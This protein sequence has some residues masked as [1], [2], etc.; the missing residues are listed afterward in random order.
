MGNPK[1]LTA[2][3]SHEGILVT[4]GTCTKQCKADKSLTTFIKTYQGS[5][6]TPHQPSASTLSGSPCTWHRPAFPGVL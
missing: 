1:A 2:Y 3:S 5:R 4:A 6:R